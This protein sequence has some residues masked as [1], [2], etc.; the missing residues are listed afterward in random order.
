[1]SIYYGIILTVSI[2]IFVLF[3]L[4]VF[5]TKHET[6]KLDIFKSGIKVIWAV[7]GIIFIIWFGR[8]LF[9]DIIEEKLV[10]PFY[11][12]LPSLIGIGGIIVLILDLRSHLRAK[13]DKINIEHLTEI[14]KKENSKSSYD[15]FNRIALDTINDL[16]KINEEHKILMKEDRQYRNKMRETHQNRKK[17]NR[18]YWLLVLK[19]KLKR[20]YKR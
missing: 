6:T 4:T 14:P 1:M 3:T 16:N 15:D 9:I 17:E 12:V 2:L 10:L 7:M 8:Y 11:V 19:D 5:F 18:E 13:R 20:L